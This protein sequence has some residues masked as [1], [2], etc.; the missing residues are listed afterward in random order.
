MRSASVAISVELF[1]ESTSKAPRLNAATRAI[2]ARSP[3]SLL[4]AVLTLDLAAVVEVDSST[5]GVGPALPE[6]GWHPSAPGRTTIRSPCGVHGRW[7]RNSRYSPIVLAN[8]S[9]CSAV[10]ARKTYSQIARNAACIAFQ[11]G[12]RSSPNWPQG[13][14]IRDTNWS[15][16]PIRH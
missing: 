8:V 12:T 2:L 15:F 7:P 6:W 1:R 9:A 11:T 13:R 16:R 10:V 4:V 14:L 3:G 5:E